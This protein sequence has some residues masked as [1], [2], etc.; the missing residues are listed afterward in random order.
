[1]ASRKEFELQQK[2]EAEYK[3]KIDSILI[4]VLGLGNFTAEVDVAL[5][6]TSEE[7]TSKTFNPDGSTVRSEVTRENVNGTTAAGGI[8][9]SLS[10]QPPASSQIPETLNGANNTGTVVAGGVGNMSKEATRNY[11]IDTV[12]THKQK[13]YGAVSKLS[14]SV[15]VNYLE[16]TVD[17]KTVQSP[18]SD[19]DIEKIRKLLEGGL[20][21][22]ATRGDALEVVSVPFNKV[23]ALDGVEDEPIYEQDWFWRGFKILASVILVIVIVLVIIKPMVEKLLADK[24]EEQETTTEDLDDSVALDGDD[25]LHLIAQSVEGN[26]GSIYNVKNG[27]VI[28]P[29]IHKDEDVLRA[30]RALVANE[31]DLAAKVVKDWL[32]A[33]KV[34]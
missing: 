14:V 31:P 25:D 23:T 22:D 20:G 16:Q 1:M 3:Q 12:I 9:G 10:N 18:R 19:V 32:E 33:E 26:G 34:K 5:D 11:E 17:G 6:F 13:A 29:D 27:Q 30:V 7:K 24:T 2:K 8:P 28:L 15:A 4:P 21:I